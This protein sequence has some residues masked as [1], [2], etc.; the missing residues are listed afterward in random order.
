MKPIDNLA[1]GLL[2]FNK[3]LPQFERA[4]YAALEEL[5]QAHLIRQLSIIERHGMAVDMAR[6]GIVSEMLT[7]D[8]DA[9]VWIDTDLIFPNTALVDLVEM[10]NAGHVC[11]A[12][13]YRRAVMPDHFIITKLVPD[14]WATLAELKAAAQGGVAPVYLTA[15]GFS[16]VRREVYETMVER[17]GL[18][19]YCNWDWV[20]KDQCGEDTFFMRRLPQ[21]GVV[22]VVDPC[23]HA[24]HWSHHGPIPVTPDAPEMVYCL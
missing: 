20:R 10:S 12:G 5:R 2:Y 9:V 23:L 6:N 15:G 22:P 7:R 1:I 14:R 11:A 16:I 8:C 13:L 18:P 24:V 21:I 19:W 4:L 17:M 3:S